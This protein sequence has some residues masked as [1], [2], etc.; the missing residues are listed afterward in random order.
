[1]V[2]EDLAGW[3]HMTCEDLKDYFFEAVYAQ[4]GQPTDSKSLANWFWG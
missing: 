4:S 3:I 2:E 1:M